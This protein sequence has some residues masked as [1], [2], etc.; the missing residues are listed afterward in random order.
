VIEARGEL[1]M[2]PDKPDRSELR[3]IIESAW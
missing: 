2:T 1:G 3:R